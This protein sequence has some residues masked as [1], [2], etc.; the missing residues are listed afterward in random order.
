MGD[1]ARST[2]LG[3]LNG[4]AIIAVMAK[5]PFSG[6]TKTRLA[7]VLG[8]DG[9]AELSAEFLADTLALTRRVSEARVVV[10]CPDMIHRRALSEL[11]PGDIAVVAQ[12]SPGLM[13][14]LAWTF[15]AHFVRGAAK[16]LL[17]D[18]DSPTL[19]PT[20]LADALSALDNVDL[21]VG[22]C[23]DGG[24]YLIGARRDCPGLFD[25]V[26]ASTASTFAQTIARA[27]SVG[28]TTHLLPPWPDVDTPEDFSALVAYLQANPHAAP[29]TRSWL[30]RNGWIAE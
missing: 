3:P 9:A 18:A 6:T 29:S 23:P 12:K 20:L 24:Y 14:G 30:T 10:V 25:G 28:L 21:C 13:A 7:G 4:R 27:H 5:A 16:V 17:V 19:L 15:Q 11:V 2:L 1:Y 22:P 26:V 8:A